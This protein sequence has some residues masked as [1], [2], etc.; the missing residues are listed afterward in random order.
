M[1]S[2]SEFRIQRYLHRN[3]DIESLRNGRISLHF[4]ELGNKF[5]M[6]DS[7]I[8]ARGLPLCHQALC[9]DRKKGAF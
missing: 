7:G 6:Y 5:R 8:V 9:I 2:L 4:T 1:A 3:G